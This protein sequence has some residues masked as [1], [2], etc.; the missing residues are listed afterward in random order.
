VSVFLIVSRSLRTGEP[1]QETLPKNLFHQAIY[2]HRRTKAQSSENERDTTAVED[3]EQ[4]QSPEFMAFAAGV[5]ALY[6]ILTVSVTYLRCRR[7]RSLNEA[8]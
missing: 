3:W 4:L 7:I 6:K 2:H 8:V 5:T 1:L